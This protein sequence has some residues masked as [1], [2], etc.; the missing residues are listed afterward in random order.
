MWRGFILFFNR[1]FFL[2]SIKVLELLCFDVMD[3]GV[4]FFCCKL[5]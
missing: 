1:V 2:K 4:D 5:L 3:E